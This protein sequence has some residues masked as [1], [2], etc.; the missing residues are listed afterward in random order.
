MK[1]N[2]LEELTGVRS[3]TLTFWS[4]LGLI[5]YIQTEPRRARRYDES[6]LERLAEVLVMRKRRL[7]IAEIIKEFNG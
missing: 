3:T 4:D 2:Q 6:S 7:S 1:L 5:P